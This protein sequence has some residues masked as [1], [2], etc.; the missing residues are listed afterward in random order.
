M[1]LLDRAVRRNLMRSDNGRAWVASL[2]AVVDRLRHE[3]GFVELRPP[4]R[5]GSHALTSPVR[6][7]GGSPAVLKVPLV[8]DENRLEARALALYAGDGAVELLAFDLESG[9]MLLEEARPGRPLEAHPDRSEAIEIACALLCRLRRPVPTDH[10][11]TLVTDTAAAWSRSLAARLPELPDDSARQLAVEAA[12]A[13]L[14]LSRSSNPLFLVNRD[15]HLGNVLAAQREPWL[16]VDPKPLA[17]EVAFDAG[18]LVNWLIGDDREP[19]HASRAVSMLASGLNVPE[20]RVHAWG[21]VRAMDNVLWALF[22]SGADSA[23]Y[24]AAAAILSELG[25]VTRAATTLGPG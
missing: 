20:S 11:F 21:L 18:Y 19:A 16:L 10:R 1:D 22:D 9:A 3:W 15:A 23:P 7:A 13:A 12:A 14:D 25:G 5:G 4:Y 17:G 6:W 24:L 2:P 8:D